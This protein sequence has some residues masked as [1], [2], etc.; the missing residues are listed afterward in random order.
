MLR[1]SNPPPPLNASGEIGMT[2][3]ERSTDGRRAQIK[4]ITIIKS[5][6]PPCAR[7]ERTCELMGRDRCS[8]D[9][10]EAT[11]KGAE[12]RPGS[13]GVMVIGPDGFFL[14]RAPQPGRAKACDC[15]HVAEGAACRQRCSEMRGSYTPFGLDPWKKEAAD[16]QG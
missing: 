13:R 12:E 16:A 15:A 8:I 14:L 3:P 10:K 2:S 9:E 6:R 11:E 1:G 5:Q 4:I 7:G